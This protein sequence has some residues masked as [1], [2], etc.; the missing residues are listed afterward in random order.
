MS[1]RKYTN[2][3][4]AKMRRIYCQTM[5]LSATGRACGCSAMTVRKYRDIQKWV[6]EKE[7]KT[8]TPTG[9]DTTL[10]TDIANTLAVG[11]R[12][13]MQ[14]KDLC[15]IA[16]I[17]TTQLRHWLERNTQCT[18][19]LNVN[20]GKKDEHNKDIYTKRMEN[21]GLRDLREREWANFE[22][23][24][25]QKQMNIQ[26]LA[27]AAKDYKT[28][29]SVGQWAL[30]KRIPKVF[31]RKDAEVINDVNVAVQVNSISLDELDLDTVKRIRSQII[32]KE[33]K[34]GE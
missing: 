27:I 19:I 11:W 7:I 23:S 17:T 14:D 33:E 31:G 10:T 26:D 1:K 3:D 25:F 16:R 15:P 4:I 12:M 9:N 32:E 22:F 5:S 29:A 24:Q 13:R 8:L 28:A 20:T 6:T 18:I 2:R 34:Q 30:E 21:V